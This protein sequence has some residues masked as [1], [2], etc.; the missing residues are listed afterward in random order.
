MPDYSLRERMLR[1]ALHGRGD[2]QQI[3]LPHARRWNDV[4]HLRLA[5][6]ERAGLVER[7]CSQR[8]Q[9]LEVRSALDQHSVTRRLRDSRAYGGGSA[10][11]QRAG[12]GCD[13]QRHAPI[14][15][16]PPV[17]EPEQRRQDNQQ[18]V[19]NQ[20]R[21]HEDSLEALGETLRRRLLRL[22][23]FQQLDDTIQGPITR[24]PGRDDLQRSIAVDGACEDLVSRPLLH[25]HRLTRDRSLVDGRLSRLDVAVH[26][27]PLRGSDDNE[28]SRGDLLHRHLDRLITSYDACH[29]RRQIRQRSDGAPRTAKRVVLQRVGE[30]K[31]EKEKRAF[32]PL[33]ENRR[34]DG[35]E[36]HEQIDVQA[37]SSAAQA[38]DPVTHQIEAA[39]GIR[40]DVER[41]RRRVRKARPPRSG[42]GRDE[43]RTGDQTPDEFPVPRIPSRVFRHGLRGAEPQLLARQAAPRHSPGHAELSVRF[44]QTRD[45]DRI[46][47]L[48]AVQQD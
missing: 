27:D 20:H 35:G 30:R 11:R 19:G 32:G 7:D 1:M 5:Q 48:R 17:P 9:V 18:Q 31:E 2:R 33:A 3:V 12:R 23:L 15:A 10:E 26:R 46:L 4:R 28:F 36:K 40:C 34:A 39:E 43:Q 37:D 25:R 16:H 45:A 6:R 38:A 44:R 41:D 22:R 24:G 21:R 29:G 47:L 13:E 42:P 14:E 8:A